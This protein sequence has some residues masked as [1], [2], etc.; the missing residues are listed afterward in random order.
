MLLGVMT[1]AFVLAGAGGV[2]AET[3]ES[4]LAKAYGNN[5]SL[6]AQRANVRATDENVAQAKSGYRPVITGTADV[7][8][9][10]S[11]YDDRRPPNPIFGGGGEEITRRTP[12]GYGVELNQSIFNGFRTDNSVRRAE[13]GVLSAR[14]D[15]SNTEQNILTSAATAYMNVLRDTAI[16]DLQRNNV[17]VIDEQLRQTRDRFNVGE[18]TRT[19]VAQAESRLAAARSE[20]SQAEANLR[21]SIAQY[22]Q[23][24]GVEPQQLAPGR[25]L[26]K[27]TPR[28]VNDALK[29]AFG[30]H[31]AIKAAQH[32]VDA[33]ELQVKI[34][35]GALAPQVGVRASVAQR[36][37]VQ[38]VNDEALQASAV[39]TLSVPIYE[40]GQAYAATRQAKEQV[41][42][43]Q[44][45]ADWVRDQVRAA[46]VSTWGALEAARA[47]I[48]AAQAQIDA[49][50]TA[51][52]GVREEAR[53]GQRTTLDVLNAQQELL[54]ARVNLIQAQRDR[55]VAS[56]QLVQSMGRL[57][58]RALGLAVNHYN[59]KIHYDQVKDLWIGTSTPDGR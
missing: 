49:A 21:A 23:Y 53:V 50:E 38:G 7:G 32:A 46:V 41:G 25:P 39:A 44:L 10:F 36:Y 33:A 58:S 59:P 43:A 11:Q 26:D 16:L 31:P 17:E 27:L 35:Q 30:E 3:L 14:E 2:S 54:T 22:R 37:D 6:N 5:P 1:S 47:Q 57:T 8:R 45:Q 19:D 55:V 42:Q 48:Q 29:V 4:A 51:L 18:V 24:I 9:T 40:G 56:Y 28:S 34:E 52:S 13:S 15:L 12:R 20:A